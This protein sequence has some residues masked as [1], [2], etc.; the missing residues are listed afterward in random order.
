MEQHP[1][2]KFAESL[3]Q[4][5]QSDG[6]MNKQRKVENIKITQGTLTAHKVV[7]NGIHRAVS[8]AQPMNNH[9]KRPI[10]FRVCQFRPEK[11]TSLLSRY[12]E[13]VMLRISLI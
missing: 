7:D 4:L 3:D 11:K 8:V 9:G 6:Y 13:A 2:N 10:C 5:I 1:N 12:T